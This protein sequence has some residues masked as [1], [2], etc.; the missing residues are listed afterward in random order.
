MV[1]SGGRTRSSILLYPFIFNVLLSLVRAVLGNCKALDGGASLGT[2][3]LGS[4]RT[5]RIRH[6]P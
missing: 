1:F 2:L 6:Q 5:L 4:H 3:F